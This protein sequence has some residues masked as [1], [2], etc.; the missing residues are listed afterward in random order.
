MVSCFLLVLGTR[1]MR[2]LITRIRRARQRARHWQRYIQARRLQ[3]I[4]RRNLATAWHP[5]GY[6]QP[7]E[8]E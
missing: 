4:H 1:G 7:G 8:T 2:D 5:D 6:T 3:A